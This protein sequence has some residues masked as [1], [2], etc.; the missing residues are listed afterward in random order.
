MVDSTGLLVGVYNAG[1][2]DVLDAPDYSAR[3][4]SFASWIDEQVCQLSAS[5]PRDCAPRRMLHSG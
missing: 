1:L 5:L 3:V 2:Y 4:S